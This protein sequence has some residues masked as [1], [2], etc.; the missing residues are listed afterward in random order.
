MIY[1]YILTYFFSDI[2]MYMK[3]SELEDELDKV[4][5]EMDEKD[6]TIAQV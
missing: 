6:K 3:E 1:I 2:H 4:R 5:N